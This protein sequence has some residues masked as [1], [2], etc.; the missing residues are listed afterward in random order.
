MTTEYLV[1]RGESVQS[2]V[3][4]SDRGSEVDIG[5]GDRKITLQIE[6]LPDGRV[7]MSAGDQRYLRRSYSDRKG[8]AIVEHGTTRIYAVADAR[9]QALHGAA[10]RGG[11]SGGKIVAS[12]PGRVVRIPVKIGDIVADGAVVAVLEAMKMENDVRAPGGGTVIAIAVPEGA[13]VEAG[14][15]LVTLEPLA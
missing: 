11:A 1:K 9:D 6:T 10:G 2:V 5:L 14:A 8:L 3:I 4:L 12:M 7:A 13:T 15:L